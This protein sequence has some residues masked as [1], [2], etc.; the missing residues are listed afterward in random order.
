MLNALRERKFGCGMFGMTPA[1]EFCLF[2]DV[3]RSARGTD[4]STTMHHFF[5]EIMVS[6]STCPT[7]YQEQFFATDF[8]IAFGRGIGFGTML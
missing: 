4:M 5:E 7:L 8:F 3:A 1:L 6:V 2:C